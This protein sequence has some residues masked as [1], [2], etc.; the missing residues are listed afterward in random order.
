M[1]SWLL[2]LMALCAGLFITQTS[3]FAQFT[4]QHQSPTA[5]VRGEMNTL[6]FIVPSVNQ[7]D[8]QEAILFFNYDEGIGFQQQEVIFENG[9]FTANLEIDNPTA[10]SVEY[11]FQLNLTSGSQVF[12]PDNSPSENPVRVDIVSGRSDGA[13]TAL[14]EMKIL[15]LIS[16]LLWLVT[17][18]LLMMWLLQ[19]LCITT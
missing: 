8:V 19:L 18:L 6:E 5:L 9:V 14:N 12:Y 11:Y 17:P 10:S 2:R 16:F 15:S 1:L 4:V 7:N 13:E 3:L